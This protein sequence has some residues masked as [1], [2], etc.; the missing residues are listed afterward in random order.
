MLTYLLLVSTLMVAIVLAAVLLFDRH[1]REPLE[2]VQSCF[3]LGLLCQLLVA[4][5]VAAWTRGEGWG[6]VLAGFA[7]LAAMVVVPL[8]KAGH[9]ELDEPY[10]GIVYSVAFI[11]G[12]GCVLHLWNL[13]ALVDGSVHPRLWTVDVVGIRDLSILL[14][15]PAVGRV[16]LDYLALVAAAALGGAVFGKLHY[17]GKFSPRAVLLSAV[18]ALGVWGLNQAF[19]DW[20]PVAAGT[21]A[22]AVAAAIFLKRRSPFRGDAKEPEEDLPIKVVNSLL[23]VLGSVT[24]ALVLLAVVDRSGRF[25]VLTTPPAGSGILGLSGEDR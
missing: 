7:V 1:D 24:L 18:T 21:V 13:P 10:D 12:A 15:S 3:S 8:R 19:T 25:E 22:A 9:P 14:T 5:P 6:T 11:S 20:W 2:L 4:L 17:R 16:A 23:L